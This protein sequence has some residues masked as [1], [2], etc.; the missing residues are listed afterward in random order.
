MQRL[1]NREAIGYGMKGKD[2]I[3]KFLDLITLDYK[4][5]LKLMFTYYTKKEEYE[6][7]KASY[8]MVL[9][10]LAKI[11]YELAL[12]KGNYN[13]A[14]IIARTYLIREPLISHIAYQYAINTV[15]EIDTKIANLENEIIELKIRFALREDLRKKQSEE[16]QE[17]IE[18]LKKERFRIMKEIL[19]KVYNFTLNTLIQNPNI[20]SEEFIY[21]IIKVLTILREEEKE[22]AKAII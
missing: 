4:T 5:S 20:D 13:I 6:K 3:M 22:K 19:K 16:L 17:K 12:R 1:I 15:S 11:V 7:V 21:S 14:G 18:Q 10:D 2:P 9:T 8:L